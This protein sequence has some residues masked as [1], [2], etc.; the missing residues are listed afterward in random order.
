MS[1]D[2]AT[3]ASDMTNSPLPGMPQPSSSRV[4][5]PGFTAGFFIA[6]PFFMV[7]GALLVGLNAKLPYDW[8]IFPTVIGSVV[9]AA[10]LTFL[11]TAFVMVGTRAIAQQQVDIHL[12]ALRD[13]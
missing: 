12:R 6:A 8:T 7:L 5:L 13:R 9:F 2:G 1:L 10:G 11:I 3:Y 4:R